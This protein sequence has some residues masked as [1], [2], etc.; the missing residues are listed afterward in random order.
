[1]LVLALASAPDVPTVASVETDTPPVC[2]ETLTSVLEP[3][4]VEAQV[5]AVV[6]GGAGSGGVSSASAAPA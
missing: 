2:T 5:V 6:L 4:V 1:V 3:D